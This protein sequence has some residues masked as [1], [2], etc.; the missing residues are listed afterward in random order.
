[1][2]K[3]LLVLTICGAVTFAVSGQDITSPVNRCG[4]YEVY[5][6]ML[7]SDP[8][9]AKNRKLIEQFTENYSKNATANMTSAV[10]APVYTIPVVVHVVYNKAEQNISDAQVLSQI[11]VLNQDYEKLNA[12]VSKVPSVWTNLVADCQIKFCLATIDP[13][14]NPTTGI[15]RV[16]TT[17]AQFIDNDA[18][19]F[20]SKGGDDAWPAGSYLNLW[21]CK[22]GNFLLGYAQF[23]GGPANTD[24][25]V[26]G[27]NAFGNNGAAKA[28]YDLG[29]TATHE[30]GHW[31]NLF[32]IWGDDGGG[33]SGSDKVKDTPDQGDR[34]F[35]CPRF[36]FLSCSNGP[37]GDMFMNYMDY[38]DDK[39]MFMFTN[40]QKTRMSATL[41]AGG[42]RNSVTVSGK[43]GTQP[44]SLTSSSS[45][46]NA[47][48]ISPNPVNGGYAN[49]SYQ[50]GKTAQ[51]Q[52]IILNMYGNVAASINAGT[53]AAGSYQVKPDAISRL[54]NG[55]YVLKLVANGEQLASVSFAVNK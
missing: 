24:G 55:I 52:L 45:N 30:I 9:F 17:K 39:C 27:Y 38:T 53:Q 32:H 13:N 19:K 29:R 36:P 3:L 16:Q 7:Q 12:D 48:T 54:H 46:E 47:L 23:P 33:C 44:V 35:G 26:I 15:R 50:I 2:K 8:T 14:G 41:A 6:R 31:L 1:M 43:C 42:S 21:V 49:I 4:S 20:T 22:L 34:H 5:Q 51:V 28:P 40:G 10:N 37:N 25:V 18:V 11:A